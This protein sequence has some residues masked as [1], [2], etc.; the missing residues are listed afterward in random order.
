MTQQRVLLREARAT[1]D[2]VEA[3]E[4]RTRRAAL[5]ATGQAGVVLATK[6]GAWAADR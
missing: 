4:H 3:A 1:P 2:A 5:A 6:A